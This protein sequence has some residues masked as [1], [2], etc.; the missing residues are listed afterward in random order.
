M[1]HMSVFRSSGNDI[2]GARGG[3]EIFNS[4]HCSLYIVTVTVLHKVKDATSYLRSSC[5]QQKSIA[6]HQ[7]SLEKTQALINCKL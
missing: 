3:H 1:N 2:Y 7:V 5:S 6:L 4:K